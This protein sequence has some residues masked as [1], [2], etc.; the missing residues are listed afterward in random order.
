LLPEIAMAST[1]GCAG[2][3]VQIL[4][5]LKMRST[6]ASILPMESPNDRGSFW[7]VI[8]LWLRYRVD[9]VKGQKSMIR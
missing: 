3:S 2:H 1:S 4:P 8:A 9:Q 7:L 6:P 5:P